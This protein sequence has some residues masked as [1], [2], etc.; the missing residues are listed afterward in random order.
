VTIAD[1]LRVALRRWYV[2]V[3]GA[4]VT[5][6]ACWALVGNA[7]S[8]V[9]YSRMEI[10]FVEVGSS[11]S[12]RFF[13]SGSQAI[14]PF[15]AAVERVVNEGKVAPPFNSR[16]STI[17][18]VGVRRGTK[19]AMPN[20]GTQW[21]SSYP[22][23]TLVVEVVDDS[24]ARVV[25]GHEKAL[26]EIRGTVEELQDQEEVPAE[27]RVVVVEPASAPSVSSVGAPRRELLRALV[28]AVVVGAGITASVAVEWDRLA[29]RRDRRTR[30][31]G[32]AGAPAADPAL[33]GS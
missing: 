9:F 13:N 18:G 24:P 33:V 4:L 2:I 1:F 23:P 32:A 5:V 19:V 11:A 15:V 12:E 26:A 3:A 29:G 17:P 22:V 8:Q 21:V 28:A 16:D 7:S 6:A 10:R 30:G 14:V 25:A 27:V 20:Y 31:A